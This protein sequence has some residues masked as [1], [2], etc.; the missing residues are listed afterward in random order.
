MDFNLESR[1]QPSA[2]ISSMKYRAGDKTNQNIERQKVFVRK[3]FHSFNT[4]FKSR[5]CNFILIFI[6]LGIQWFYLGDETG[7]AILCSLEK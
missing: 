6:N 2:E 7:Y 4:R 1:V 3:F 5:L